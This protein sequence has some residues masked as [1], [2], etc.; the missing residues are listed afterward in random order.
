MSVWK[1]TCKEIVVEVK[2]FTCGSRFKAYF[3]WFLGRWELV[4][5]DR[6]L[7]F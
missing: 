7:I 4:S 6:K 3:T 5:V 1:R 2:C